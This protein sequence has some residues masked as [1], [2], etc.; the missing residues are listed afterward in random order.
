MNYAP[1]TAPNNIIFNQII[2]IMSELDAIGKARSNSQGAGFKY[3]GIDDVYNALHALLAKHG[4]FTVPQV[5]SMKREERQSKSGGVLNYT[6]LTIDFVFYAIDGSS[7]TATMVGEAMDSG[8]KS[9]N[10]A[11]SVAH[12]YA[13]LQV[14]AIPTEEQKDPDAETHEPLPK[15]AKQEAWEPFAGFESPPEDARAD[16]GFDA[17]VKPDPR[18]APSYIKSPSPAQIKRLFAI[19]AAAGW[20]EKDLRDY[21]KLAT[22]A[23]KSADI[24]LNKYDELCE[25]IKSHPHK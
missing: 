25:Y 2:A 4:V 18:G 17:P 22:G 6:I 10:K 9:S 1:S 20:P 8:D 3:R 14:F 15:K 13:F 24:P 21:V 11:M 23:D 7:V 12:K 16:L 5:Q 19:S